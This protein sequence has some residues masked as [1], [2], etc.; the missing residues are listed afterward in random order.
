[1]RPPQETSSELTGSLS[2][3]LT[4][5]VER[6]EIAW[7][8]APGPD[9]NAFLPSAGEARRRALVELAHVDLEYRLKAGQPARVEDYLRRFPEL[10]EDATALSELIEAEHRLRSRQEPGLGVAEYLARFPACRDAILA[11]LPSAAEAP[12]TA[13]TPPPPA[14]L[15]TEGPSGP[16]VAPLGA[17]PPLPAPADRY[18]LGEEIGRGGMGAVLRARDPHLGRELA[19]KV[20]RGDGHGRPELLRRFVEE[21]QVC[22]Q[23]Q[24]PGI[25]PV[26]DLGV[27]ADGRPFFAMKLV[28][29]RTLTELLKG[30]SAPADDLA[31]FLGIFEAVC[32][33]VAYAHSK[34]VIHRDLKPHNVMVGAFGEVQVM[35]WG[36]AKVLPAKG[37]AGPA[38]ETAALSAVR[39]V[40]SDS[41]DQSR[42]GQALGTPAYMA[43]E[44]ARGEVDR[45]DERCDVFGLG[46]ILCEV[47]TAKPPFA[48]GSGR[49]AHAR[50]MR[51][52]LG[53][54]FARL[55]GCG[56]DAEL[57]ALA[58]SC[59]APEAG[60]R[61]RDA[62]AVAEAV[63]A[64]QRSVQERLR[65]AELGRAQAEV[66]AAEERKRRRLA[67][68][69]AAAVVA[70]LALLGAGLLLRQHHQAERREDAARQE[71]ALRQ[72]VAAVLGQAA[73]LRRGGHFEEALTLL[74]QARQRLGGGPAD[75]YD[76]VT[77]ASADTGLARRLDDTRQRASAVTGGKLDWDGLEADYAAALAECG[78]ARE[79]EAP[80]AVAARVQASAVREEVVAAL[81]DWAGLTAD[82]GR[83]TWLLAVARA[84]DP[85]PDG[86]RWRQPG[87]WRDKAAL[88]RLAEGESAAGLSPQLATALARALRRRG[89]DRVPLLRAAQAGHPDDFWL[90]F[91]L[92]LALREAKQSDEA[93]GH[94]R[95]ALALRP[96]S[97]VVH[98][99]LGNVLQS[100]GRRAEAI[101]HYERAVALD[102]DYAT[103]HVG[104]GAALHEMGRPR[105]AARHYERA[106][107]LNPQLAVAHSNLGLA[108]H[109]MGRPGEALRH[110]E[111]AVRLDPNLAL[112]HL[113]LGLIL[114][115]QGK[116]GEG[117]RHYERAVALDPD[118]AKARVNLG[119]ALQ[120]MGRP[121]EAIP[122]FERAVA[123]EPR[124]ASAHVALG[125]ALQE[126][127]RPGEAVR[128]FQQALAVAPDYPLAHI[129]LGHTLR[130]QGRLEE[131]LAHFKR[132]HELGARQ[133]GWRY[134]SAQWVRDAERLVALD[135]K[136]PAVLSG[137]ARPA[138][139]AEQLGLAGVCL[140]KKQHAAAARFFADAFAAEPPLA[141]ALSA[142]H[143]YNAA[144]SAALASAGQGTDAPKEANERARLRGQALGWLRADLAL[145]QKQ[146]DSGK[147]EGRLTAQRTLR[148]WQRDADL[149]GVRDKEALAALPTGERAEWEKFWAE[150]ADLLRRPGP[151]PAGK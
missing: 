18:E 33:A 145:W 31:R 13:C 85:G 129:N 29:G 88:L 12:S 141:E 108:L 111:D 121:G 146:A 89:G 35:D 128:R 143:R 38:E 80:E 5:I 137:Q 124:N 79:G 131:S 100:L 126:T 44:Q 97:T 19:V 26:H 50:A 41:G 84:A 99:N 11:R 113:N 102:A 73:S 94:Y 86:D 36:L 30:R 46:A 75:L 47:L 136:L 117:L 98:N 65:R 119:V 95:A 148:H 135:R 151:A 14:A 122:H 15:S 123:L 67:A 68:G 59:L 6:F 16:A 77:R 87:L 82:Q 51:G 71:G 142:G 92:G 72:D 66:R 56:A 25:V 93:L 140:L 4:R 138:D 120:G 130:Q 64:Y 23:L 21:A 22:S 103:A 107:A 144:C 70:V 134:P 32:Q 57:L 76:Q 118:F 45:L 43:P 106:I 61:P 53:D 54:A 24:H 1:M 48:G 114:R 27:L 10:A 60:S 74:G 133:P 116:A 39:T 105:E 69:L 8:Q 127:G 91:E 17:A 125:T 20:L 52:D 58:K 37:A 49:E 150:V 110:C 55:D 9:L 147:P 63:T 149:A 28:R 96:R 83:Q 139:A 81:D 101:R 115:A 40:R 42:D 3:V 62:G 112:A 2:A 104:L 90:H 34:G 109:T 78:L 7:Q 132:G